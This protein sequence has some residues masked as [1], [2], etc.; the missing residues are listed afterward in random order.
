MRRAHVVAAV[1]L[2]ALLAAGGGMA[3][4]ESGTLS[5]GNVADCA[6]F[7]RTDSA[8]AMQKPKLFTC[9]AR[10]S[11]ST[12]TYTFEVRVRPSQTRLRLR[13]GCRGERAEL[14]TFTPALPK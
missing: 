12:N 13:A 2:I 4:G 7:V 10:N 8:L 9:K 6:G 3:A 11:S 1:A 14:R 5:I